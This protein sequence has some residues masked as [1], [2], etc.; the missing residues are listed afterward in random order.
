MPVGIRPGKAAM[1]KRSG[2]GGFGFGRSLSCAG[3]VGLL[4]SGA[5]VGGSAHAVFAHKAIHTT[6]GVEDLLGTGVEG[7]VSAPHFDL[8]LGLGGA[9]GHH[10]LSIANPLGVGLP[11]GMDVGLGHG[12]NQR[13][14]NWGALR[15][16]LRP[17]LRRSLARGSRLR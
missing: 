10:H 17:Y 11:G 16:F 14:E 3:G 8:E 4:G 7:M 9:G 1:E 13:W 2:L 15:A 6:L 12:V 5:G